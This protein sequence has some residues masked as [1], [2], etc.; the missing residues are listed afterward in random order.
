ML[1][2]DHA[3]ADKMKPMRWLCSMALIMGLSA[4]GSGDEEVLPPAGSG[5]DMPMQKSYWVPIDQPGNAPDPDVAIDGTSGYGTVAYVYEI[6]RYEVTTTE[7]TEFLNAKAKTD[8]LMQLYDPFMNRSQGLGEGCGI[9]QSGLPGSYE[10]SVEPGR[11]R[12]PV[13]YVSVYDAMRFANWMTNGEGDADTETGAYTLQGGTATPLN[14]TVTRNDV[15]GVFLPTENE[16]YKAAYYDPITSV[17]FDWPT[18]TDTA[19]VCAPPGPTPNTANCDGAG[20]NEQLAGGAYTDA[21]AYTGSSSPWG[22]YDQGGNVY[23]YTETLTG[24]LPNTSD[25]TVPVPGPAILRVLSGSSYVDR[26]PDLAATR[27]RSITAD[28]NFAAQG[29][30]VVRIKSAGHL[31]SGS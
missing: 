21:G 20:G 7:Y 2:S 6:G 18:G 8:L 29:F 19:T 27:R 4:C 14:Y 30:R 9:I 16:W 25:V 3:K 11:E 1:R 31:A 17:Y 28:T 12:K 24:E 5:G 23:D 26:Q 10:Y 13:N 22:T 15:A